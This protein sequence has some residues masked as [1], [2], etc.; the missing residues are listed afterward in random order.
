MPAK[1]VQVLLELWYTHSRSVCSLGTQQTGL[2]ICVYSNRDKFGNLCS[3]RRVNNIC[4]EMSS[5]RVN[6]AVLTT[7]VNSKACTYIVQKIRQSVHVHT[8][9]RENIVDC[10]M[11]PYMVQQVYFVPIYYKVFTVQH[12]DTDSLYQRGNMAAVG[13]PVDCRRVQLVYSKFPYFYNNVQSGKERGQ[14]VEKSCEEYVYSDLINPDQKWG[15]GTFER[16]RGSTVHIGETIQSRG[17]LFYSRKVCT[18]AGE[19]SSIK[20]VKEINNYSIVRDNEGGRVC[21]EYNPEM[22]SKSSVVDP[23]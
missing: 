10:T 23:E 13:H 4:L 21:T 16:E 20:E 11:Y 7:G 5:L 2:N 18:L 3:N 22:D 15:L 14:R 8:A 17:G 19:N 12:K 6:T 9:T 1:Q